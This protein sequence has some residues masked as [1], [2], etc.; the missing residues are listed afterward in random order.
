L[1]GHPIP[2]I[3][4]NTQLRRILLLTCAAS[5]SPLHGQQAVVPG[6]SRLKALT[7]ATIIGTH[8]ALPRS[9][10]NHLTVCQREFEAV[11]PAW[12]PAYN[13]WL[14]A[15][16]GSLATGP[17]GVTPFYEWVNWSNQQN[18]PFPVHMH[19]LAGGPGGSAILPAP[20]NSSYYPF[21]F[22][23]NTSNSTPAVL[24][25]R[26]KKMI[27]DLITGNSVTLNGVTRTN[28][29]KVFSWDV[30][31]E[32]FQYG[33]SGRYWPADNSKLTELYG[34]EADRSGYP[35]GDIRKWNAQHP[36]YLA[37]AFITA[38]EKTG[39][40]LELRETGFEFTPGGKK[41]LAML[42]LARHLQNTP[43]PS[44]S[45]F[46]RRLL[47][48]IGY[49]CHLHQ[50]QTAPQV[51][52]TLNW[53]KLKTG[54]NQ[55]K[56]L[57]L[58][59]NI[60]ELDEGR[61][62]NFS[63]KRQ[64]QSYYE[65]FRAFREAGVES[66]FMWGIQD[67][68]FIEGQDLWRGGEQPLLF[69]GN[70]NA[71]NAYYAAQRALAQTGK[72]YIKMRGTAGGEKVNLYI[73]NILRET[74]FLSLEYTD[75]CYTGYHGQ[76]TIKLEFANDANVPGRGDLN[77]QIDY[78]VANG[79]T[80]QAESYS[81]SGSAAVR[82]EFMYYNEFITIPNVT[83]P[84]EPLFNGNYRITPRV[85]ITKAIEVTGTG[86][87]ANIQSWTYG[88][89]G[90]LNQEWELLWVAD[91]NAYRIISK[92]STGRCLEVAG[93]GTANGTAVRL[94][95]I[96]ANANEQLWTLQPEKNGWFRVSPLSA[97][98]T[99]LDLGAPAPPVI[100]ATPDNL[101]LPTAST[102]PNGAGLQIYGFGGGDN[103]LWKF[104]AF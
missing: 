102:T 52:E 70:F 60:T 82:S 33:Q 32:V 85:D 91:K 19:M 39:K 24:K 61:K 72:F 98:L 80:F 23:R 89:G 53:D 64:Y 67:F 36:R 90:A 1:I 34:L 99:C 5:V 57:G 16:T 78:L 65:A 73:D 86:N 74:W 76:H 6:Y 83:G 28:A 10:V 44:T 25:E 29:D 62:D 69:D 22:T 81:H 9:E 92:A 84:P 7:D 46:Q 43:V 101:D 41:H 58:V 95:D 104:E 8:V 47:N 94:F 3:M 18:P 38:R 87:F 40:N 17:Y 56:E 21:W 96:R 20:D 31:N 79:N 15:G 59:V 88:A 14:E 37:E 2:T 48:A 75:Y 45:P 35:A 4:K 42:Q 77:V 54:I 12:Y 11:Q 93:T 26:W 55:F 50:T 71:K 27:R 51:D 68:P 103:Q 100:P 13:G 97:P 49:Q 30:V 63:A 66:I